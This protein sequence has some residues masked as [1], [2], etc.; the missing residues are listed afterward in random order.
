M[1]CHASID[2]CQLSVGTKGKRMNLLPTSLQ[3]FAQTWHTELLNQSMVRKKLHTSEPAFSA[4]PPTKPRTGPGCGLECSHKAWKHLMS[5]FPST[6]TKV[7]I[8]TSLS[9]RFEIWSRKTTQWGYF[10]PKNS[11]PSPFKLHFLSQALN[12]AWGTEQYVAWCKISAMC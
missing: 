12:I 6:S 1:A 5:F 9:A 10:N 2:L 11:A 7:V 3:T 8:S 4:P